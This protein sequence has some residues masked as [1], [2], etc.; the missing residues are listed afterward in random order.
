[1]SQREVPEHQAI[2]RALEGATEF[3]ESADVMMR[4]PDARGKPGGLVCLPLSDYVVIVPD[5]HARG[6]FLRAVTTARL[7]VGTETVE[8]DLAAGRATVVCVGDAFHAEVR[9]KKRWRRAYTEFLGGYDPSPAMDEEMAEGLDVVLEV[10]RLQTAYPARFHFLKGNHEN[11]AN[12]SMEGN[13]PFRKFAYEGDMVLDWVLRVL[14]RQTFDRI[15]RWEKALPLAAAGNRFLVTHAEPVRAY[16]PRE[17]VDAYLD[18]AT[19]AG[20]TWTDNGQAVPGSVA[21]TLWGFFPGDGESRIFGGHRPVP[22]RFALRQKER[23]V[24]I[25][26][27]NGWVAAAFGNLGDFDPEQ[28]VIDL[29]A[30]ERS[31]RGKD[32]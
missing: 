3:L 32:T 18:P 4:P 17:I 10:A 29:K 28:D 7:P 16:S 12:E 23:F 25:N 1:M 22:E 6:E 5:L 20:L 13:Y 26:T 8:D 24:Q 30:A 19:I 2:N 9:A 15:Y 27:P 21:D 11:V 14:G 31:G